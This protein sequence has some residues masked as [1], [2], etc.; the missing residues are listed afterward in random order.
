[1]ILELSQLFKLLT[2][3]LSKKQ[4]IP[5][6]IFFCFL[7]ICCICKDYFLHNDIFVKPENFWKISL[8]LFI[9]FL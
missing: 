3:I 7:Q 4:Q 9:L 5:L 1:M 2:N 6:Y 8:R